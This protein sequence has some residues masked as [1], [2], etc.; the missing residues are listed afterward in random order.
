MNRLAGI[1]VAA[2]GLVIAVLSVTKIVP[3]LTPT[4]VV[5]ILFGGLIIG[6]S[7]VDKPD[8]EGTKRMSTPSTLGNIF[9]S[10]TEVF[11]NLRRHPRFLVAML[12]MSIL[13]VTYTNLFLFRLGPDRVANFAIDKTLEMPMIAGNEDA[14]K[15]V[16]SG[17]VQALA[18]NKNPVVKAGQA[19][20]AFGG[21]AFGFAFLA[22]IFLLFS[23]AMGGKINFWQAFSTAVYASFPVSVLRFILNTTILFIKDPTDI[24][25]ILGQQSLIQ[26]NL[27]FLVLASEHPVIFTLLGSI[28]L[29]SFYWLW[30]T[31][32]GLKNAGER[33]TG[34]I[35]WS[36]TIGIY[37]LLIVLGV[38]MA[39]LFPSFIS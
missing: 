9:V 8:S 22:L 26:D 39:T 36:A 20:T 35:A 12:I 34:T 28:S 13:S 23:M 24:H 18:D 21:S 29:L 25:P 17:R 2:L 3:G 27:N 6:L 10:P 33:V 15:Q 7:F 31:A 19:L 1:F 4:G 38:A 30:L 16:E 37:L 5:M 11:Q 32:T 14:R